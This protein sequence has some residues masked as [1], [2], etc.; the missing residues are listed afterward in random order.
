M[1]QFPNYAAGERFTVGI[2]YEFPLTNGYSK[3]D[4][5]DHA[6]VIHAQSGER[7]GWLWDS[8]I[9]QESFQRMHEA[10]KP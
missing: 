6:L 2:L 5:V 9:F 8:F 1:Y 10:R 4:N 7:I 3:D